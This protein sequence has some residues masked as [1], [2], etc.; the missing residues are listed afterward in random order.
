MKAIYKTTSFCLLVLS[1]LGC[2]KWLD[3]PSKTDVV[4]SDMLSDE[5][6]YFDALTGV[7]YLMADN[8]LYGDMLSMSFLD[9]L[10]HRYNLRDYYP[11]PFRTYFGQANY[12]ESDNIKPIIETI[13]NNGYNAIANINNLLLNID[14]DKSVF[15]YDNYNLIK[16]EALGLRAFLHFD[17]LRMFGHSYLE[18]ANQPSIPYVRIFSGKVLTPLTSVSAALDST[19]ADLK[20]AEELL[21]NDDINNSSIENIWVNTRQCHFNNL[22]VYATLARVYLYKGDKEN[23]LIYA[24]KVINANK[25]TFVTA[26]S[27]VSNYTTRDLTFSVEQI[28]G[29]YKEDVDDRYTHY[30]SNTSYNLII[31]SG[32]NNGTVGPLENVYEVSSGGGTDYRYLYLFSANGTTYFLSKYTQYNVLVQKRIPLIRLP[33]MYYIAAEALGPSEGLVYLNTVRENRGLG[34]LLAPIDED[35]FQQEIFKEYQKEFVGEG[36]LFYYYKRLNEANMMEFNATETVSAAIPGY[37][38]PMPED[39]TYYE[40][41]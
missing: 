3:V 5:Q 11:S 4:E 8:S 12:Y 10:A 19:I 29:L 7:Y 32:K 16:G 6:G 26:S 21:G 38:F 2:S 14:Q 31:N 30:F 9:V 28:F 22:A 34:K 15:L 13:W 25:L 37:I 1:C 20:A 35:N 24:K 41:R 18:G 40:G 39:E 17:L 23:A 36:Q 33:E 27:L